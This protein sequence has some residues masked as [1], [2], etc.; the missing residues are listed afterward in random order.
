MDMYRSHLAHMVVFDELLFQF[1][2]V[3]GFQAY[4]KCMESRFIIFSFHMVV[5]D[6]IKLCNVHKDFLELIRWVKDF[7]SLLIHGHLSK[8]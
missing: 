5:K 1:A 4:Y 3:E 8:T 2:E 6:I 7:T